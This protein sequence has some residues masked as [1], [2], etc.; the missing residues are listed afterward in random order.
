MLQSE[1][2]DEHVTYMRSL[3]WK[4]RTDLIWLCNNVLNMPDVSREL[5][6]VLVDRLQQFPKPVDEKEA[7]KIMHIAL[8]IGKSNELMGNDD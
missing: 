1:W 8:P 5:N 3:R 2:T 7:N 6:G 4:A